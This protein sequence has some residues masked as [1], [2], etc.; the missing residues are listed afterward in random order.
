M[1]IIITLRDT[2]HDEVE[3]EETRLPYS[4]ESI[5]S[6]TVASALADAM[7]KVAEQLGETEMTA[8]GIPVSDADSDEW[9]E[10]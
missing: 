3:I 10:V 2:D 8:C 6:V 4:G 7:L 1:E 5:D 9:N